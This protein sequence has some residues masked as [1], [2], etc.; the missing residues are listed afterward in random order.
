VS[1]LLLMFAKLAQLYYRLRIARIRMALADRRHDLFFVS[2]K[3]RKVG[4][5]SPLP[6]DPDPVPLYQAMVWSRTPVPLQNPAVCDAHRAMPHR[7]S[8]AGGRRLRG[9]AARRV[10]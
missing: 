6:R 8:P 7:C 2:S 5:I 10:L 4:N 3:P 1:T 9:S